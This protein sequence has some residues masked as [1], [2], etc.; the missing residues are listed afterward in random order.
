MTGDT[1]HLVGLV[2][3]KSNSTIRMV[4]EQRPV[5]FTRTTLYASA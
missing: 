4:A 1:L 5:N 3:A 2:V